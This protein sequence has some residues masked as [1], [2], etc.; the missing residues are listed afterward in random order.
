MIDFLDER[1][2]SIGER[3]MISY[4]GLFFLIDDCFWLDEGHFA[5]D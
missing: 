5:D 3:R 2:K 1:R 4:F